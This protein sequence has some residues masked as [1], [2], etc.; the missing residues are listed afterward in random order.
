MKNQILQIID[1]ITPIN[2]REAVGQK[3][4]EDPQLK[5]KHLVITV[6]DQT[7]E[8]AKQLGYG[9]CTKDGQPYFYNGEYWEQV[10]LHD[11]RQLLR[12]VGKKIGIDKYTAEYHSFSDSL[13][14]QFFVS[15][16][17]LRNDED[18]GVKINLQ[19]GTY[20]F[21]KGGKLRAFN[22]ADYLTYQL[23]FAYNPD[24]TAPIFEQYL[25]KVLPDKSCQAVL[26]EYLGYVFTHGLR[27]DKCLILLG[28]GANGKSV[29]FDIACAL[30]GKD[31]ITNYSL[32]DLDN[33]NARAQISHKLL[34]YSSEMDAGIKKDTFKQLVSGEPIQAKLLYKDVHLIKKYAKLMFNANELPKDV[35]YNDAFFRRWLI[36]PFNVTIPAGEQD[37]NL[38][39]RIIGSEL[40]GIFNWVLSGLQRLI[41]QTA[42]TPCHEAEAALQEYRQESDSV[43]Q[44]IRHY[45]YV[46]SQIHCRTLA[47]V[48]KTYTSFCSD[49][50]FKPPNVGNFR[51]R[52]EG[53]GF[54]SN[55]KKIGKM[56]WMADEQD[57]DIQDEHPWKVAVAQEEE[58]APF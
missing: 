22:K 31:N 5:D 37:K 49:N 53:L 2:L 38:S 56:I 13:L 11:L 52:M 9:F 7:S 24:A 43:F 18:D 51:K 50:G 47:E 12:H 25:N 15:M 17:L 54:T 46:P 10:P 48:Y 57:K 3:D 33:P 14:K 20:E 44:F 6:V 23:P 28:N 19:N 58:E 4:G 35:E 8:I 42:F 26:A 45:N 39:G 34:N 41:E 29:F 40:S 32:R 55:R 21:S 36:V 30:L 16:A 1:R 27:M